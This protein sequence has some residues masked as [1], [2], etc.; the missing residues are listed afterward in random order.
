[1]SRQRGCYHVAIYEANLN[2]LTNHIE[3]RNKVGEREINTKPT[4]DTYLSNLLKIVIGNMFLAC[5][6][7]FFFYI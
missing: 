5:L 4:V 7:V 2:K 1:M 3:M 6:G